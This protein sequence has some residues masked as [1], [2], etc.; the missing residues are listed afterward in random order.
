M[1]LQVAAQ[2]F[3]RMKYVVCKEP[4]LSQRRKIA[5]TCKGPQEEKGIRSKGMKSGI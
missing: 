3:H 1:G 2:Y 4:E 5:I